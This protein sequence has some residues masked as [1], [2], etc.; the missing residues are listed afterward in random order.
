VCS[1]SVLLAAGHGLRTGQAC[2]ASVEESGVVIATA[3]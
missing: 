2:M 1:W 3:G